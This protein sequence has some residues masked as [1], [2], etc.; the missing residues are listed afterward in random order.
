MIVPRDINR[1]TDGLG[2][3][4]DKKIKPLV[5]TLWDLG[6][7]TRQSCEGHLGRREGYPWVAIPNHPTIS[8]LE[9]A[10]EEYNNTTSYTWSLIKHEFKKEK[11]IEYTLQPTIEEVINWETKL[12]IY[13][14]TKRDTDTPKPLNKVQ[15]KAIHKTIPIL[16]QYLIDYFKQHDIPT[17]P[18]LEFTT[19]IS[20][21]EIEKRQE[22][23]R[24]ER[25]ISKPQEQKI[26]P[27]VQI[28]L[29]Y[30]YKPI[31]FT[32][33]KFNRGKSYPS[34]Q[35]HD[36]E[37][38][39]FLND[40]LLEYNNSHNQK[41]TLAGITYKIDEQKITAHELRPVTEMVNYFDTYIPT[42]PEQA[43]RITKEK[44][45]LLIPKPLNQEE[46]EQAQNDLASLA[47]YIKNNLP[48]N[49]K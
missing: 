21:Q 9:Q 25:T 14:L 33:G 39:S 48:N 11:F 29:E 34:V 45:V 24:L 13:P 41:W 8:N 35:L 16:S 40:T 37:N 15:L 49:T 10:I 28:L 7:E 30:G 42:S 22:K 32:E 5:Q 27:L 47:E 38:I 1:I 46:L 2:Y 26:K 6:Y 19:S 12:Q 17:T 23:I 31:T 18:L 4:I 3:P 36:Q 44:P 43:E 20:K